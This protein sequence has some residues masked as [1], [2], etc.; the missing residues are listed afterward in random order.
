M[1][2][3]LK[4]IFDDQKAIFSININDMV[5][6]ISVA[7]CASI[8]SIPMIFNVSINAIKYAGL[9]RLVSLIKI[10]KVG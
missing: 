1:K 8:L 7:D 9:N 4:K 2:E 10:E 5:D 6:I 3:L